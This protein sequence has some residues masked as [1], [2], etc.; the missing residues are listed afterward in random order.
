MTEY[1]WKIAAAGNWKRNLWIGSC[2]TLTVLLRPKCPK[3]TRSSYS[4]FLRNR[5]RTGGFRREAQRDQANLI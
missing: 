3:D 4:Q 5:R 2:G 1:N